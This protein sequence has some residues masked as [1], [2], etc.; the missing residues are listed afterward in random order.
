MVRRTSKLLILRE[1]QRLTPIALQLFLSRAIETL[2]AE[3]ASLA[4]KWKHCGA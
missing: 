4:L 1:G 2:R 3:Q